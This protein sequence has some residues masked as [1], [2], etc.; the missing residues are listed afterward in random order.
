[1]RELAYVL[2]RLTGRARAQRRRAQMGVAR[3]LLAQADGSPR[4]C[5]GARCCIDGATARSGPPPP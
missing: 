4:R 3:R 1:M 5:V 2:A